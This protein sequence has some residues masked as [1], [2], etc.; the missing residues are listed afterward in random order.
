MNLK[1]DYENLIIDNNTY[2]LCDIDF[3]I[4]NGKIKIYFKDGTTKTV[5]NN[6]KIK[7]RLGCFLDIA[8]AV[9]SINK[10][11]IVVKNNI[12]LNLNNVKSL[13][14]TDSGVNLS[15]K[16]FDLQLIDLTN[17]QIKTISNKLAENKFLAD[18]ILL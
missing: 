3:I 6:Y 18:A 17:E 1:I 12:L 10:N 5:F 11:F 15:T 16:Y 9:S 4:N 7:N 14:A 8:Y 2:T 13:S